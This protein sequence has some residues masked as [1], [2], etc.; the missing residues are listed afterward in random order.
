VTHRTA[1]G[2]ARP[3]D[4]AALCCS[5]AQ[6]NRSL[7]G[8]ALAAAGCAPRPP[9]PG[10]G[11]TAAGDD[12][13][14]PLGP[15]AQVRA[16][17]ISNMPATAFTISGVAADVDLVLPR[18]SIARVL[19][20]R[21]GVTITA[22]AAC[23]RTQRHFVQV[24][25]MNHGDPI[26]FTFSNNDRRGD[27][28]EE[29]PAPSAAAP[30]T[31]DPGR[32]AWVIGNG[33]YGG[34]W[35]VLGIVAEDRDR[36]AATLRRAGYLVMVSADR[37]R[38]DLQDDAAAFRD[39]LARVGPRIAIIYVSGH[40]VSLDGANHLVPTDAPPPG[41]IRPEHLFGLDQLVQILRPVEAA[42]G[43]AVL[44]VDA[45]RSVPGAR[46]QPLMAEPP[47][48][49]LVNHS[50]AP[51]GTSFDGDRGMSA[52][53]ERFVTVATDFPDAEIDQLLGYANRYTRWQSEASRRVQAPVLYGRPAVPPPAFGAA[54][55]PRR[56]V[57][58]RLPPPGTRAM[59]AG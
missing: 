57:L 20:P 5:R 27:C 44:L 1:D 9:V 45:C 58:P 46:V 39:A 32:L 42:G 53:T 38:A 43:C 12:G 25:S 15:E 56:G 55:V 6:L 48:G 40:G 26:S 2:V 19:L 17:L 29:A 37:P 18:T 59:V 3:A 47:R 10:L 7:L 33:R 22:R 50:T 16:V 24:G 35:P 41:A 23:F 36:M 28:A 34:G 51:G 21:A 49:M 4:L 30:P 14:I 31:T 52:W 13:P 11:A 8:L 54:A